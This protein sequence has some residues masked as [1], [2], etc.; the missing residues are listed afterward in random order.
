M[1][2]LGQCQF[3]QHGSIGHGVNGST[4]KAILTKAEALE[5][6][7]GTNVGGRQ[8]RTQKA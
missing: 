7:S 2:H 6:Q 4:L 3:C 1:G 5:N 8:Q